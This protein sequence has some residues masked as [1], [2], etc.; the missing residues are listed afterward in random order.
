MNYHFIFLNRI[1]I[2][3]RIHKIFFLNPIKHF[4]TYSIES[5]NYFWVV[6]NIIFYSTDGNLFKNCDS[7]SFINLMV[8]TTECK[9]SLSIPSQAFSVSMHT[10]KWCSLTNRKGMG[11][12]EPDR[13]LCMYSY[14][15]QKMLA[16]ETVPHLMSPHVFEISK[17]S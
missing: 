7:R 11:N 5:H 10:Q 17:G 12:D 2:S 16:E 15:L 6:E 1:S 13:G 9:P 3:F 4:K 8:L 14:W